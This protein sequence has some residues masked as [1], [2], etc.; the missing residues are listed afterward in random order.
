CET[1]GACDG[2]CGM[3]IQLPNGPDECL[4][5]RDTRKRQEVVIHGDLERT[6]EELART[7]EILSQ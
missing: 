5:C 2:R 6:S 1:C 7:M 4:N 3:L